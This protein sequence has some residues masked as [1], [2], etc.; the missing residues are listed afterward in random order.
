MN[1]N[2]EFKSFAF[3]FIGSILIV[4]ALHEIL[5]R[6]LVIAIGLYLIYQGFRLRKITQLSSFMFSFQD[7][8]KK[9]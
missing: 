9:F 5:F 4:A 2:I 3:M 6:V 8:F 7:Q 1:K